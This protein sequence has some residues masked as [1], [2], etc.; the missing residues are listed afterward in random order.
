MQ[1]AICF[2]LSLVLAACGGGSGGGSSTTKPETPTPIPEVQNGYLLNSFTLSGTS[3]GSISP[4]I[5]NGT[6]TLNWGVNTF[7]SNYNVTAYLSDNDTYSSADL[8]LF[9]KTCGLTTSDC[10]K[11]ATEKAECKYTVMN[12]LECA[13][14]I[15]LLKLDKL[16]HKAHIILRSCKGA[17]TFDCD[18][19]AAAITFE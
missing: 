9:S 13:G 11:L 19:K 3:S 15:A 5:N 16:P 2:T 10:G 6:F 12:T 8:K 18:T 7:D 1:K 4:Y 14:D 17:V